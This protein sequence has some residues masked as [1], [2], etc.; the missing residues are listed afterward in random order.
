ALDKQAVPATGGADPKVVAHHIKR[1]DLLER[2]VGVVKPEE[3]E[4]WIRQVADSLGTAAQCSPAN[5]QAAMNR[6]LNLEKQIVASLPGSNLAGYVVYRRLQA[7]YSVKIASAKDFTKLQT[8][9]AAGLAKFVEI[10]A[11]CEDAPEA[12]L[13]LGMVNEFLGKDVEAKN[14]Y[15][16]LQKDFADKPQG[17]K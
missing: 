15:A 5:D 13:Q 7:D 9:W 3:R 16:R 2:I 12:L 8:E 10:Y 1:A 4:S 6:L 14:W 17:A 11:K